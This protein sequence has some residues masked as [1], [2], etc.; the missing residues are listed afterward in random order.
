MKLG[1]SPIDRQSICDE[2]KIVSLISDQAAAVYIVC[3]QYCGL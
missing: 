2:T 3:D 1:D